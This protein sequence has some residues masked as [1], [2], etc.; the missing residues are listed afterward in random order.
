MRNWDELRLEA[1]AD[2][3]QELS[4]GTHYV[5]IGNNAGQGLPLARSLAKTLIGCAAIIYGRSLPERC[6]YEKLNTASCSNLSMIIYKGPL[7]HHIKFPP[8]GCVFVD[9][10]TTLGSNSLAIVVSRAV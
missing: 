1:I 9:L 2:P 7:Y 10:G 5:L 8:P 6:E 3:L 4:G